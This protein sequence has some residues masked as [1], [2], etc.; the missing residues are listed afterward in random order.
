MCA[1]YQFAT[2][3]QRKSK[4]NVMVEPWQHPVK[5]G[6]YQGTIPRQELFVGFHAEQFC[7]EVDDEAIDPRQREQH[8]D[9]IAHQHV[10]QK[11]SQALPLA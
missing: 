10:Q 8:A 3:A 7:P 4:H 11:H 9:D 6:G 1:G 2:D 5:I